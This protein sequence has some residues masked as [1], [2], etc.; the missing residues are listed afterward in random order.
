MRVVKVA[1]LVVA[2]IGS[3]VGLAA[4]ASAGTTIT[5][6]PGQSIQRAVNHA[7]AGDTIVV[8]P[9]VY[10]QQVEITTSGITLEGSGASGS[11]TVLEPPSTVAKTRCGNQG[12]G[13]YIAEGI[14]LT[15]QFS[16]T[17]GPG[18]PV[19]HVTVT[20][21]LVRNFPDTGILGLNVTNAVVAHDSALGNAEYGI[22]C[23]IC[24]GNTY[25]DNVASGGGEAG[26]YQGDSPNADSTTY[27]N[28]VYGNEFGLFFRDSGNGHFF[29]NKSHDNC[30]G[31]MILNTGEG[32]PVT[33]W[34]ADHNDV[35]GNDKACPASAEGAPALSGLGFL[36]LGGTNNRLQG[37][38]VW[39]NEPG[40]ESAFAGGISIQ[41]SPFANEASSSNVVRANTAYDNMPYDIVWDRAGDG[42]RFVANNC[43]RSRPTWICPPG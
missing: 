21:F 18:T 16:N 29:D 39:G 3:T 20:N 24:S 27:G 38:T 7:Q 43:A 25:H 31:V 1:V 32:I 28:E 30:V 40:G 12:G 15:G 9:G 8:L 5:V 4:Q 37:N 26:I 11:G 17:G 6:H 42:N 19:D 13:Q 41:S 35:Y 23:F 10:H 2:M 36:M 22:A 34:S 14:C 33:N